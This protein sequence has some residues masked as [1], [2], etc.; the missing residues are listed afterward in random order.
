MRDQGKNDRARLV[1]VPGLIWS[2]VSKFL[3][4]T[5]KTGWEGAWRVLSISMVTGILTSSWMLWRYPDLVSQI[6]KPAYIEHEII[7]EIFRRKPEI[8]QQVMDL[9]GRYVAD[10]GPTQIALV[11]WDSQTGIIEVWANESTRSWP[12]STDGTM[13]G[14]MREAVGFMIFDQCWVGDLVDYNGGQY[15]SVDEDGWLICG[16]SND[17]DLWGYVLV[18]WQGR[19]PTPQQVEA[20]RLLSSRLERI[21]FE[22]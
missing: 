21:L 8:R 2:T 12:V 22:G 17:Y 7:E 4:T 5:P 10:F 11:N 19:E 15:S 16:L 9:L 3:L 1:E 18:H 14:N 6:L 13:S 20:L